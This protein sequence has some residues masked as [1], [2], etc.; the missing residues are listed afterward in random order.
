MMQQKSEIQALFNN[1]STSYRNQPYG[2]SVDSNHLY[3][4]IWVYAGCIC[5]K[6]VFLFGGA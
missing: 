1:S 4:L 2:T 5:H 6:A 3:T